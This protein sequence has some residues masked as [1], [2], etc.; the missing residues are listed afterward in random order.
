MVT[1]TADF[2]VNF[3]RVTFYSLA[4]SFRTT[5]FNI[6]KFC[7]VLALPWVFCTDLRTGS[8]LCFIHY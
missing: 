1:R 7:M 3:M 5:K 4:V 2:S 8:D 6:W